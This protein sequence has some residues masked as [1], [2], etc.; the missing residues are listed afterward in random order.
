MDNPCDLHDRLVWPEETAAAVKTRLMYVWDALRDENPKSVLDIGCGT[1]EQLTAY[2]ALLFPGT[3]IWG[4]DTD[5]I[6]IDHARE[7][8]RKI[9]NLNFSNSVPAD[10]VFDSVIASEV[11]EHVDNPFQFLLSLRPVLR[12]GG[13]LIA[14]VPNG[15]G[16]SE[17]MSLTEALLNL[18]GVLPALKKLRGFIRGGQEVVEA[19][20]RDTMAM[21]P[22]VN[23][24]SFHRVRTLFKGTGFEVEKYQGRMLLH[25][26]IC[27]RVIDRSERLADWNAR[28]GA[29]F[30]ALL[31][32]D[33]M[34]TLR[35]NSCFRG[36]TPA[37]YHRNFYERVRKRVNDLRYH[38]GD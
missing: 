31:V 25:N 10:H 13:I 4:V 6:S 1:G 28:M 26:F 30:P 33:W 37:G 29:V 38:R 14:T 19:S 15:Y 22:H 23:F 32:S 8:Y 5:K 18:T 2:L 11:L 27:S 36:N 20:H 34:F 9:V 7:K 17:M 35:K 12:D 3:E 24:F 16:C 21:S